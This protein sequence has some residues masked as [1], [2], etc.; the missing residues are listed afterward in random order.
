MSGMLNSPAEKIVVSEVLNT[1]YISTPA[2][3]NQMM[4]VPIN[5]APHLLPHV[6]EVPFFAV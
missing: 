3:R 6:F 2:K 1:S 5:A 4:T